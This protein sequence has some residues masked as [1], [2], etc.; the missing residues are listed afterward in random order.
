MRG[1][2]SF[3]LDLS[4]NDK[5]EPNLMDSIP[6]AAPH[7]SPQPPSQ[8]ITMF[9]IHMHVLTME[10]P[11]CL[12]QPSQPSAHVAQRPTFH[13][14]SFWIE[15]CSLS[16]ESALPCFDPLST[17][18]S[19]FLFAKPKDTQID[20]VILLINKMSEVAYKRQIV[21]FILSP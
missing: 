6:A 14:I 4:M 9:P 3:S 1:T 19:C 7:H 12:T 13:L 18:H 8:S 21:L 16:E 17:S 15:N 5:T 2:A 10:M 11:P 20:Y